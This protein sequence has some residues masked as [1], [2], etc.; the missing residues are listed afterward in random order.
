MRRRGAPS[1]RRTIRKP[2]REAS[3]SAAGRQLRTGGGQVED[4]AAA[5]D[6][7]RATTLTYPLPDQGSGFARLACPRPTS[8]RAA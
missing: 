4:A 2:R 8:N 7:G 5:T 3:R 6:Q 1:S